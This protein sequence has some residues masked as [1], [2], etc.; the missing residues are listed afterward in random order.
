MKYHYSNG[1]EAPREER[2]DEMTDEI[3]EERYGRGKGVTV[4]WN[5]RLIE[6]SVVL[7]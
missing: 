7:H 5:Y 3:L 1:K 2:L 6:T 4:G